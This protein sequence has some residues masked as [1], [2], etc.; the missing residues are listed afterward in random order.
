MYFTIPLHY[1][2]MIITVG[3]IS[4]AL[5]VLFYPTVSW[6]MLV[7]IVQKCIFLLLFLCAIF[8]RW[9]NC[10]HEKRCSSWKYGLKGQEYMSKLILSFFIIYHLTSE[11]LTTADCRFSV[12]MVTS[13]VCQFSIFFAINLLFMQFFARWPNCWHEKH[14]STWNYGLKG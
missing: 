1:T 12:M 8:A 4:V 2:F 10:W 13:R 11:A 3:I 6:A 9:P 5:C 14:C 7:A